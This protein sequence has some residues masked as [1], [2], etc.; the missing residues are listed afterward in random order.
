MLDIAIVIVSYNTRDLLRACL[1]S[2]YASAGSITYHVTVVDN[3]SRDGSAD[4]A[5]AEFPLANV[6]DSPRNGGYSYA[7]NLG[8]R[9]YGFGQ[10]RNTL[11]LPHYALLL[12]P[13][14]ELPPTALAD[15]LALM[16]RRPDLGAAG[17][18]LVLPDGS[19]DKACRRSFPSPQA[20]IYR[21]IGLSKV[22]PRSKRFG[23][24]NLTYLPEDI[25]TEVDSVVGAFMLVRREAI[26]Q[27]GLLDET[28]FMYGEDLDWAYR[29]K[30]RGWKVWYY[31]RVQV[32]HRKGS[33]SRGN[34]RVRVAFYQ[35]M[36]IFVRKHYRQ[37]TPRW[38][39]CLAMSGIAVK[40]SVDV[41]SLWLRQRLR[42]G[43]APS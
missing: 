20:F 29:I 30:E 9:V 22:F 7:N 40:G 34:P 10:R 25:E 27:A 37:Q 23:Q 16:E 17:P 14:T 19:L 28:F 4:M 6:V 18:K 35:A 39:Y 11:D 33:A 5:R 15:M 31:P 26:E 43:G 1:R 42:L 2:V 21:G 38:L 41:G 36:Q 32:L 8:L 12:N 3:R 13:D 24:Y